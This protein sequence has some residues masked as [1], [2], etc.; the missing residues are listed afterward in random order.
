MPGMF[1]TPSIRRKL[2]LVTEEL[3]VLSARLVEHAADMASSEHTR[4]S[5]APMAGCADR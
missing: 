1:M 5:A 2:R 4:R 3:R